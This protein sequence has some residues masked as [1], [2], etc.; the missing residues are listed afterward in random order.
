MLIPFSEIRCPRNSTCLTPKMHF[1]LF[2][3]TP[4]F[5]N[6]VKTILSILLC[7][8]I[9]RLI[10]HFNRFDTL[11]IIAII[12]RITV[13]HDIHL[14]YFIILYFYI[15]NQILVFSHVSFILSFFKQISKRVCQNFLQNFLLLER[16]KIPELCFL[17][18]AFQQW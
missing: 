13:L 10:C 14:N 12:F 15:K 6:L 1:F 5:F 17:F 2:R 7:L 18:L 3:V 4:S 9:L 11:R 16:K 8:V